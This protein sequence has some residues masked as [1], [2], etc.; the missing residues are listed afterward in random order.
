MDDINHEMVNLLTQQIDTV[1]NPLIQSINQSYQ[2]L[3]TQVGR[4]ADLFAP[5]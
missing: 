4:I 3:A 2:A 5:P 1:F